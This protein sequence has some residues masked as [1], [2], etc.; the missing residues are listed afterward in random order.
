V[1][2]KSGPSKRAADPADRDYFMIRSDN[3]YGNAA[4]RVLTFAPP[5]LPLTRVPLL[6]NWNLMLFVVL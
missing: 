2:K 6:T 1:N 4:G 3:Y 5:G